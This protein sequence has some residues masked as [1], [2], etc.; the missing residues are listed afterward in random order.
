MPNLTNE[1]ESERFKGLIHLCMFGL[2]VTCTGYNLMAS[3][4][5]R[6]TH[7]AVNAVVYAGLSWFE[8]RQILRHLKDC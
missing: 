8:A 5:R 1:G 3:C 4:S 2:A 7:L 6:D